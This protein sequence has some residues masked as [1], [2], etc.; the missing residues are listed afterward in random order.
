MLT[1]GDLID[2]NAARL[3]QSD[4]YV[5]LDRRLSWH[6][7]RDRTD[8]LVQ[9]LRG[10]GLGR[11]DRIGVMLKDSIEVVET[12]GACAKMGA[13][14]V[15]LNPR[16]APPELAALIADAG[17]DALFVQADLVAVAQAALQ[18]TD[19]RPALI[20]IGQGHGLTLDYETLI[21]KGATL[22]RPDPT[23]GAQLMICYTTGSTG[24]PKGAIYPHDAM[25][26]SMAAIALAEG[27]GPDDVWLH[28]MPASGV[29]ILHLL[30]NMFHGSRCAIVGDWSAEVALTLIQRERATICVLVPTMLNDLLGSGLIPSFDCS[31]LRQLGYGSA[32]IPPATV[33]AALKAFG[34]RFLQMYG[35][36]ELM[37]MAMMLTASDHERALKEGHPCLASAGR[38]MFNIDLRVIDDSGDD[39]PPDVPGELLIRSPHV[40]P[41]Y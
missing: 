35:T 7:L 25:I 32:P 15:G 37:G 17:L 3:G 10:L 31:S 9:A 27:A 23:P 6:D 34:C 5:E 30:R 24:Q 36:T 39:L 11:G 8:A 2:R 38:A 1:L 22:G 26:D 28:A 40:I 21:A 4:A 41:G 18:G 12:I 13:L 20:G 29:P 33:R 16:L 14:R 19:R